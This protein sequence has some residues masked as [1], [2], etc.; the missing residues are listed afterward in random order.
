M[1][2][3]HSLNKGIYFGTLALIL[4]VYARNSINKAQYKYIAI[5]CINVYCGVVNSQIH[6]NMLD[7]IDGCV[8]SKLLSILVY[9][10]L[11]TKSYLSKYT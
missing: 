7:A 9:I 6:A 4:S 10:L 2:W 11:G 8:Q 5:T 1:Y 3:C